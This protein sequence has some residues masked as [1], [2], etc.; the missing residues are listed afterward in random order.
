MRRVSPPF[1]GRFSWP[2]NGGLGPV[3]ERVSGGFGSSD[4]G[5]RG[6]EAYRSIVDG[7]GQYTRALWGDPLAG[8]YYGYTDER[9]RLSAQR[10][11]QYDHRRS[12]DFYAATHP[13]VSPVGSRAHNC[14]VSSLQWLAPRNM[15]AGCRP[16]ENVEWFASPRDE[17]PIFSHARKKESTVHQRLME[18]RLLLRPFPAPAI[19]RPP[20]TTADRRLMPPYRRLRDFGMRQTA[21]AGRVCGRRVRH[22]C[23]S[24]VRS[25]RRSNRRAHLFGLG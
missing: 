5:P 21:L 18:F 23:G 8:H 11:R 7:F 4:G 19:T 20:A 15:S 6:P 17:H 3:R 12:F 25:Q 24:P 2:V 10:G 16:T 14:L 9:L 13:L 22:R 1:S